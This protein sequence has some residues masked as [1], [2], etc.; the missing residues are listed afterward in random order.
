VPPLR[1][2]APTGPDVTTQDLGAVPRAGPAN[3]APCAN[4]ARPAAEAAGGDA[5][6]AWPCQVVTESD[7]KRVLEAGGGYKSLSSLS[8]TSSSAAAS[9]ARSA[10][11]LAYQAS[12]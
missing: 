3:D 9:R 1:P 12:Q 10:T 5:G 8:F 7:D 6:L 4:Q 11:S 2:R